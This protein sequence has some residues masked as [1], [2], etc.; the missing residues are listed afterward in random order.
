MQ[1]NAPQPAHATVT[2]LSDQKLRNAKV[3]A[4]KLAMSSPQTREV[5]RRKKCPMFERA[6]A[7]QPVTQ[8]VLR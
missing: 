5:H 4:Y 8:L 3:A 6:E 7:R 2:N 1:G